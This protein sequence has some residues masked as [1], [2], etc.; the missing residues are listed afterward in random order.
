[1]VRDYEVRLARGMVTRIDMTNEEL[2]TILPEV[3]VPT[4]TAQVPFANQYLSS[5]SSTARTSVQHVNQPPRTSPYNKKNVLLML[6][7][8]AENPEFIEQEE[9]VLGTYN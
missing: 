9:I 8:P 1:M 7:P 5:S 6:D 4:L 2:I 3:L